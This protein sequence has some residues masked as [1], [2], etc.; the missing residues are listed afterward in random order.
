MLNSLHESSDSSREEYAGEVGDEERCVF[1]ETLPSPPQFFFQ[2]EMRK[3]GGEMAREERDQTATSEVSTEEDGERTEIEI[4]YVIE[5]GLEAQFAC[6]GSVKEDGSGK[7]RLSEILRILYESCKQLQIGTYEV[8]PDVAPPSPSLPGSPG[9]SFPSLE[10]AAGGGGGGHNWASS[11]GRGEG[12]GHAGRSPIL[13]YSGTAT[14]GRAPSANPTPEPPAVL[15]VLSPGVL[16]RLSNG[17]GSS[18]SLSP[19]APPQDNLMGGFLEGGSLEDSSLSGD[20]EG[21]GEGEEGGRRGKWVVLDEDDFGPLVRL[22]LRPKDGRMPPCVPEVQPVS[23][24]VGVR[25]EDPAAESVSVP[26]D[27]DQEEGQQGWREQEEKRGSTPVSSVPPPSHSPAPL[28]MQVQVRHDH[29]PAPTALEAPSLQRDGREYPP[30]MALETVVCDEQMATA[31]PGQCMPMLAAGERKNRSSCKDLHGPSAGSGPGR[32]TGRDPREHQAERLLLMGNQTTTAGGSGSGSGSGDASKR[33]IPTSSEG[34]SGSSSS[35]DHRTVGGKGKVPGAAQTNKPHSGGGLHGCMESM[36]S[37]GQGVSGSG[38]SGGSGG[39]SGGERGPGPRTNQGPGMYSLHGR[40]GPFASHSYGG[41][42]PPG[43]HSR[44]HPHSL[45]PHAANHHLHR[46]ADYSS[47]S[48]PSPSPPDS[49]GQLFSNWPTLLPA[50]VNPSRQKQQEQQEKK[51]LIPPHSADASQLLDIS[52]DED[53]EETNGVPE[54]LSRSFPMSLPRQK[55]SAEME[56]CTDL[57]ASQQQ[58]PRGKSLPSPPA[59]T[60]ADWRR[61]VAAVVGNNN[62]KGQAGAGGPSG[63]S[64]GLGLADRCRRTEWTKSGLSEAVRYVRVAQRLLSSRE[65]PEE[66]RAKIASLLRR[67]ETVSVDEL[68]AVVD[69]CTALWVAVREREKERDAGA[70]SGGGG[71]NDGGGCLTSTLQ[72]HHEAA[73][74]AA[75]TQLKSRG[76]RPPAAGGMGMGVDAE[77]EAE[78]EMGGCGSVGPS[79][80]AA[81]AESSASSEEEGYAPFRSFPNKAQA[82]ASPT[83]KAKKTGEGPPFPS[84]LLP[85]PSSSELVGGFQRQQTRRVERQAEVSARRG[86]SFGPMRGTEIEEKRER[87]DAGSRQHTSSSGCIFHLHPYA[88]P[89]TACLLSSSS[90]KKDTQRHPPGPIPASSVRPSKEKEEEEEHGEA[91]HAAAGTSEGE[92]EQRESVVGVPPPPAALSNPLVAPFLSTSLRRDPQGQSV[93]SSF[94]FHSAPSSLSHL[95]AL[96]LRGFPEGLPGPVGIVEE[97]AEVG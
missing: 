49:L 97:R 66:S 28:Q 29:Q 90:Q 78:C 48:S 39:S 23:E 42:L 95:L 22:R 5:G 16:R 50:L 85:P 84:S 2:Q 70:Y 40:S 36:S 71:G 89:S 76:G 18:S 59:F 27:V 43:R 62:E 81:Q 12:E 11:Q 69:S 31:P 82:T 63:A 41:V 64:G 46:L 45:L 51:G 17:T 14:G 19:S 91:A 21:D 88:H 9:V 79:S 60:L 65:V 33:N 92:R 93:S 44:G 58:Q 30:S 87:P 72:A 56:D 47:A 53:E 4:L 77:D 61:K 35:L 67:E 8:I 75:V 15:G 26:M 94:S 7:V 38:W 74:A 13:T 37:S 34:H 24:G 55:L 20:A 57:Q 80:R 6:R 68:K 25:T 73:A 1:A 32:L 54:G 52:S 86:G 96:G 83:V 3:A 10:A